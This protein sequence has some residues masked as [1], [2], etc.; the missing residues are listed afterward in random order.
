M[1]GCVPPPHAVGV[2]SIL[3]N[4]SGYSSFKGQELF[5]YWQDGKCYSSLYAA[6]YG[7]ATVGLDGTGLAYAR[8]IMDKTFQH[9]L[10]TNNITEPG[11]G[12]YNSFQET[13]LETCRRLPGTCDTALINRVCTNPNGLNADD[14]RLSIASNRTKLNF[15]GCYAPPPS[16]TRLQ[17]TNP[18]CDPL[19][20]R[21]T[22]IPRM[23]P[24]GPLAGTADICNQDVCVINDVSISATKS[25]VEGGVSFGQVCNFCSTGAC[26]CVISG[27]NISG[28]LTDL[29]V[30]N[31]FSSICGPT[32][33]C[34]QGDPNN[35][36]APPT[37]VPCADVVDVNTANIVNDYKSESKP[38]TLQYILLFMGG[39]FVVAILAVA[40][41][42]KLQQ[43]YVYTAPYVGY[44]GK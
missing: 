31:M 17:L 5:D 28:I 12:G 26:T 38:T 30:G 3:E 37:L 22:T 42:S 35:P 23:V 33:T 19:C 34:L 15:C 21:I 41:Y 40:I 27:V 36:T 2:S 13:L 1:T 25:V 44:Q 11:Q 14:L 9:Y 10:F 18:A 4:C 8:C 16:D 7:A 24:S 32:S 39:V 6:L 20:A 43:D 29:G